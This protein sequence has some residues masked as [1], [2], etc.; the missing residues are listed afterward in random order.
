MTTTV[1]PPSRPAA[2]F[3]PA[4]FKVIGPTRK[5]TTTRPKGPILGPEKV[6]PDGQPVRDAM[7]R[8]MREVL[9]W[10][11]PGKTIPCWDLRIDCDGHRWN[12]RHYAAGRA[13]GAKD[14]LEAGFRQGLFFDPATK[15]FVEPEAD[16]E[17]TPTVF[18]ETL[19]WWR[20][21][22]STIE[23]KSRKETLRYISRPIRELVSETTTPCD[24][25]DDYLT[26]Q[27]LPPKPAGTPIPP[28]H[29]AAAAWLRSVSLPVHDVDLAIW[30]AYV[31]RWRINTRTGRPLAQVSFNRHLTDIRQLWSWVCA[32]HHLPDPWQLVQSGARSSAGGRR[33]STVKPVDRTIV[34]APKHVRELARLCGAGSFGPLSEVYILLLG[35]GGGRPG[36][37]TGVETADLLLPCQGGGEVRF[38]KTRRRGIDPSFLDADDD[39]LWGPLKGREIEENRPA[40]LPPK[41]T[42]RISEL[43]EESRV[44]GPLFPAWDWEKFGR[45]IWGPA[46]SAMTEQY[47][48]RQAKNE[49]ERQE[50]DALRSA[51]ARLRLHDLRHAA[52]SMWLNTPGVEV[53]VACEWSGHKRL[54][55]FLDIYQGLMPGSKESAKAKLAFWD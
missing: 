35:V 48:A 28:E 34:L 16:A 21:H 25:L 10:S 12:D 2:P 43:I 38:K 19:A 30:Q 51:L 1:S 22:W 9:G 29:T 50:I 17:K 49:S 13:Q 40:P 11:Q 46:K 41:D 33:G 23:P 5:E 44:R 15:R 37:S 4:T 55:V 20:A 26:W 53:R 3:K 32:V 45:D 18:T 36:E 39:E 42:T 6:G 7:G 31:D 14:L 54:S 47:A 24:G 27:L 8:T 52:C